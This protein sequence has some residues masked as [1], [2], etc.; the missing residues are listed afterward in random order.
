MWACTAVMPSNILNQDAHVHYFAFSRTFFRGEQDSTV[1]Y[2]SYK[3]RA[4]GRAI[5]VRR[6]R[7]V[8]PNTTFFIAFGLRGILEWHVAKITHVKFPLICVIFRRD[9]DFCLVPVFTPISSDLPF[10]SPQGGSFVRN[11]VHSNVPDGIP[12][13]IVPV[14]NKRFS[15]WHWEVY[16]PVRRKNS[17]WTGHILLSWPSSVARVKF[18]T[19]RHDQQQLDQDKNLTKVKVSF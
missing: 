18:L 10:R 2:T 15:W 4:Y 9:C 19:K 7:D 3:Q 12:T 1:G 16:A 14:T 13:H 6:S 11:Y 8:K 17:L 5:N